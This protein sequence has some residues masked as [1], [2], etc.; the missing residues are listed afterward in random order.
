MKR[1]RPI[2][3]AILALN[4]PKIAHELSKQA[5][6]PEV[7]V[8]LLQM[9]RQLGVLAL[10]FP[11]P[12]S[13]SRRDAFLMDF[14][15]WASEHE[16]PGLLPAISDHERQAKLCEAVFHRLLRDLEDCPTGKLPTQAALWSV[17]LGA[18][19]D[20]AVVEAAT[21]SVKPEFVGTDTVYMSAES[22]RVEAFGRK[23]IDPDSVAEHYATNLAGYLKMTG[24]KHGLFHDGFLVLPVPV[25]IPAAVV[26]DR[27]PMYLAEIWNQFEEHWGKVRY[28]DTSD[29]QLLNSTQPGAPNI[30]TFVHDQTFFLDIEIARSRLRRQVFEIM[31]HVI[32]SPKTRPLIGDPRTNPLPLPPSGFL[33]VN[34][35]VAMMVLDICYELNLRSERQAYLNLSIAQWLRGY[36][37]LQWCSET[38]AGVAPCSDGIGKLDRVM[39]QQLAAR[40]GLP[41]AATESFLRHVTFGAKSRDLWDTPLLLDEQ[42]DLYIITSLMRNCNFAE[43]L[44]SR[45]N[46]L[47]QQI[48]SKGPKFEA[49]TRSNFDTLGGTTKQFKYRVGSETFE[50]DIAVLW[51]GVLFLCECK[52]YVL[53][54]P[55]A[56]DIYFFKTKQQEAVHQIA[57]IAQHFKVN[58]AIVAKHFP[59]AE[60]ANETVPC[61][62]NQ[63]PFWTGIFG[64][65]VRFFDGGA[66]A[67]FRSGSID[68]VI[69]SATSKEDHPV[70]ENILHSLWSGSLPTPQDLLA[71]MIMPFQ[72]KKESSMWQLVERMIELN[73]LLTLRLPSLQRSPDPP[74]DGV[75][76]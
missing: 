19:K 64:D 28:F 30:V 12:R 26:S 2:R 16:L 36:A 40:A 41:T 61:V 42:G 43:A 25:A 51:F 14:R 6:T 24:H 20:A 57:R 73:E 8:E 34:E 18:A 10:A 65:G 39:F 13:A 11:N 49:E 27:S 7:G 56:E 35:A 29:V 76:S 46:S 69:R 68:A 22:L 47:L 4:F 72:Y 21:R 45:L 67:M 52:A 71:Q 48:K 63:A 3:E 54:Q 62:L 1:T 38:G 37:L 70:A 23:G 44:I 31:M 53:P 17:L 55:S 60:S 5:V 59:E 9:V 66:L 33:S 58:P 50:C 74:L 15:N 32:Y 75:V